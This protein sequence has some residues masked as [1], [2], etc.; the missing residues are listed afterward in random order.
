MSQLSSPRRIAKKQSLSILS[1]SHLNQ[2][3]NIQQE[4]I[5]TKERIISESTGLIKF[6][7]KKKPVSDENKN[8]ASLVDQLEEEPNN[9][10]SSPERTNQ[11]IPIYVPIDS[12]KN[13]NET[14]DTQK[15]LFQM[16]AK[17]RIVMDLEEQLKQAKLELSELEEAYKNIAHN[18]PSTVFTSE[19]ELTQ[20]LQ[21]S[22]PQRLASVANSIRKSTSLI[23]M[24]LAGPKI[25]TDI[26]KTQKQVTETINQLTNNFS[27]NNFFSKSKNFIETNF[28]QKVQM[29]NEIL[30]SI[31]EKREAS[32]DEISLD[33]QIQTFDYSVDM[34][35]N[36]LS[37]MKVSQ[38]YKKTILQD[39]E[40]VDEVCEKHSSNLTRILSASSELSE[41]DYG[42]EVVAI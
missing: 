13:E 11:G 21:T 16:A 38:K 27:K 5:P 6:S 28:Q 26:A 37:K 2:L 32:D 35:L 30:S 25:N 4:S 41:S 19:Q 39:L 1:S 24:N 14:K 33:D 17:Q 29:G 7:L 18:D 34:D 10:T 15:I 8:V 9:L 12:Q 23:N 31:F 3:S 20:K 40:D 36:R 22:A 42:G